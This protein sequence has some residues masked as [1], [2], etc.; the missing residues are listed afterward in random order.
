MKEEKERYEEKIKRIWE[1]SRDIE[2][3]QRFIT[4]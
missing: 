4:Q 1:N 3:K 2:D